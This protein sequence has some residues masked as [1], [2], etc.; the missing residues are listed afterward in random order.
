[1][2]I[3]M[4]QRE[5]LIFKNEYFEIISKIFKNFGNSIPIKISWIIGQNL[6]QIYRQLLML[7]S[8]IRRD[9]LAKL[10]NKIQIEVNNR[11]LNRNVK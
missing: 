3:A 9:P 5:S 4:G 7:T 2:K 1:M 10:I 8:K 6:S 11:K